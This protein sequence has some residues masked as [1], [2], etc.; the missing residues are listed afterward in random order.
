MGRPSL[1]VVLVEDQRQQRFVRHHLYCHGYAAHDL[2]FEPLP[3]GKGSGAQW[4]LNRYAQAVAA[5][6]SRSTRAKT[7]LVVAI[8]ADDKSVASR[9]QQFRGLAVRTA[10]EAIV[11]FIP[12]WSIETWIVCLTGNIVSE[13][14]SYRDVSDIDKKISPAANTFFEWSR[15]NAALPPHCIPSLHAAI[16]EVRRL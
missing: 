5:Y 16:S 10:G 13:N 3:A 12:K 15:P 11:H 9:Q 6:R 14:Q 8:D 7:A 2:R 1:I 4:V